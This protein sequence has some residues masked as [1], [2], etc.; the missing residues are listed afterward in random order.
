MRSIIRLSSSCRQR[1]LRF[2]TP[3]NSPHP[4]RSPGSI[5]GKFTRFP[6][7][8]PGTFFRTLKEPHYNSNRGSSNM[9]IEKRDLDLPFFGLGP[10]IQ[11]AG[12]DVNGTH[13][14]GG[15]IHS[16]AFRRTECCASRLECEPRRGQWW[17]HSP[18]EGRLLEPKTRHQSP[19]TPAAFL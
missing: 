10:V 5:I 1:S 15:F 12:R 9:V 17:H 14:Y 13:S 8:V 16:I 18:V 4:S 2:Y 6:P 11:G 3:S 7:S 19:T